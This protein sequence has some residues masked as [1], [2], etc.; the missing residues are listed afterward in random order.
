MLEPSNKPYRTGTSYGMKHKVERAGKAIDALRLGYVSNGA[1]I[2]AMLS[3]EYEYKMAETRN[4]TGWSPNA[5]FYFDYKKHIRHNPYHSYTKNGDFYLTVYN[6]PD[7]V[8][9]KGKEHDAFD[10]FVRR[11][12]PMK[13]RILHLNTHDIFA[14]MR[15]S[16][17]S[18]K[19]E[20][21]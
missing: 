6:A 11:T 5:I 13:T 8:W 20:Q 21:Q 3:L 16:Y 14:A 17:L 7:D 19:G 12:Y 4:P 18:Q 15:N 1:F 9:F 10:T 2:L